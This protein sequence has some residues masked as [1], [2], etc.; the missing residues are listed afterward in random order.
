MVL[1]YLDLFYSFLTKVAYVSTIIAVE[2]HL[3][4]FDN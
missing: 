2:I 4:E 3:S 1:L